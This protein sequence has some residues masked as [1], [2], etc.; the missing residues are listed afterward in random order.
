MKMIK[1]LAEYIKDELGLVVGSDLIVGPMTEATQDEA[2]SIDEVAGG[3]AE[4][5]L[6]DQD[7]VVI[8]MICRAVTRSAARALAHSLFSHFHQRNAYDL[9][10][11]TSGENYHI[12][13]SKADRT[14]YY[15]GQDDRNRSY[16]LT[17][18]TFRV[19]RY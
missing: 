4:F 13:Y 11:L 17:S 14:P 9:P 6:D 12:I 15:S 10:T 1:E 3:R 7:D 19:Q 5:F 16:Y 18:I 8:D 2:V